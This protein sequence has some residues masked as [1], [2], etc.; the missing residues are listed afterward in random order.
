MSTCANIHTSAAKGKLN[1]ICEKG[2]ADSW[3]TST[4]PMSYL[5]PKQHQQTTNRNGMAAGTLHLHSV[6]KIQ[7]LQ[8]YNDGD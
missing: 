1:Q 4:T 6:C 7:G 2:T 8:N 3:E 5:S